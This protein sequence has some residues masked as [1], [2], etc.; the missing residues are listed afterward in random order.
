MYT[1]LEKSE[2]SERLHFEMDILKNIK[3]NQFEFGISLQ[4][5]RSSVRMM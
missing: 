5:D 1:S 4:Q 3:P 2:K